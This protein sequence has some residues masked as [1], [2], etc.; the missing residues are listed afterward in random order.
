[1]AKLGSLTKW[2]SVRLRT[3]WSYVWVQLQPLRS[4]YYSLHYEIAE[5]H[6]HCLYWKV[7]STS[8]FNYICWSVNCI[9]WVSKFNNF[10]LSCPETE[11]RF[12]FEDFNIGLYGKFISSS[13]ILFLL[14]YLVC[15]LFKWLFQP[16]C[17][18]VNCTNRV[19]ES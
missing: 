18:S 1:M 3:N 9:S 19:F 14:F 6:K 2:L 17:Q 8:F 16:L 4:I 5:I 7:F 12:I 13:P 10:F 15:K 11:A